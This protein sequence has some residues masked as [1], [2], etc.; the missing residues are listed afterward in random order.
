MIIGGN[1]VY[2]SIGEARRSGTD[3]MPNE[4]KRYYALS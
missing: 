2:G 1:K 4:I 3:N